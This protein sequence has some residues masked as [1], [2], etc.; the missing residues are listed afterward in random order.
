MGLVGPNGS[1]KTTILRA[2]LNLIRPLSGSVERAVSGLRLGYVPQRE[3]LDGIWPLRVREV[4]VMGL[5]DRIGL[6]RRPGRE[7]WSAAER[8]MEAVGIGDLADSRFASLSGGQ[9]QRTLIARALATDPDILCLDEP[10]AGMDISGAQAILRLITEL[11]ASGIT[12]VCVTHLLND[13][14]DRARRIALVSREGIW[15]G[16]ADEMITPEK[17]EDLYG[18]PVEVVELNG[19]RLVL[20]R[21]SGRELELRPEG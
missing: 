21:E 15:V 8:A 1:G 7:D 4:V 5:Y 18:I 3:S 17:L 20:V 10:T 16:T 9:K 19:R 11:H 12:V 13:V 14:V 6:F 2:I